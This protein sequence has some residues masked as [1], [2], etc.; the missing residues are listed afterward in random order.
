MHTRALMYNTYACIYV[1]VSCVYSKDP[2]VKR[3]I[4]STIVF[5]GS[6]SYQL[7][8]LETTQV[9]TSKSN[10]VVCVRKGDLFVLVVII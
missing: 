9:I 8:E 3:F 2:A 5:I 4:A 10:I 6:L 1:Q 7:N